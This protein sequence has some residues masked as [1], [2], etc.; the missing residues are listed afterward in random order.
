MSI[1]WIAQSIGIVAFFVGITIFFHRSDRRFRGQLAVYSTMISLHFF[2]MGANVAGVSA[3]LN[4]TRTV[5]SMRT[6]ST[7]IMVVFIVMTWVLGISNFKHPM[8]IFPMAGTIISTWALFRTKGLRIRYVVW[9]ATACWTIDNICLGSIGGSLTEA[10]F[11]IINVLT[12]Y[13]F[14][15]LQRQG[16]DPFA[17]QA[18]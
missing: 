15:K 8:E 16:I 11:L 12:I 6:S 3:L 2:L 10:S 14:R 4:T 13:R 5:I 9:F 17:I 1:Y 7:V 18:K